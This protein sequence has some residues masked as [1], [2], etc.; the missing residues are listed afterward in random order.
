MSF[1]A[2][3]EI[4]LCRSEDFFDVEFLHRSYQK[5]RRA[6]TNYIN[7]I[8]KKMADV[9]GHKS[10]P[11]RPITANDRAIKSQQQGQHFPRVGFLVAPAVTG[12]F[13]MGF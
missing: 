12:C 4:F 7:I 1:F 10:I 2:R 8:V 13:P 9:D 11:R 6:Y 5:V 3:N